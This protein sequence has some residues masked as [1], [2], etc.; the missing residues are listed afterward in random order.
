MSKKVIGIDLGTCFS[1]VSVIENGKPVIVSNSE[2]ARTTPSVV[3]LKDGDIKVGAAAN[4]QKVVNPKT[5]VSL[6]KRFMGVEY[7]K[8]QEAMKHI[9]Y[10]VVNVDGKP[11]VEIDG[12]KYSP[13][14][15]SSYI[16]N[17][18]KKTAEDYL[19]ETVT[20][21]VITCPA[22]FDSQ[23]REATKLAGE[24]CGLNVLRI[25]AEPTSSI[26]ASGIEVKGDTEKKVLVAD[27]GGGTT[28][29]SVCEIS[30]GMIEVRASSGS[31]YLGGSNIDDVVADYIITT[32]DKENGTDIRNSKD[33]AQSI[34][35]ILE[36][37]E[38]AKIELTTSPSTEISLPYITVK[39]NQ[40]LHLN[41]TLTKA[42]FAQLTQ[43][44]IDE[45]VSYG[46]DA[47]R[48]ANM[49]YKE[50]DC[51]LLVGG[52]SRST[53]FQE[54]LTRE[55]GVTLNKGVNPDEAVS[56]GAAIQAN[57]IVGGEGSSDL[58][59]L[60]INP[61]TLGIETMGGV[62][63]PLIEANT[64]IPCKKSQ[65]FTTA[66]DNQ[67]AVTIHVLQGERPLSKDN[68]S[69]G[70][71]TLDGIPPAS[72]HTPKVEVTFD[73]DANGI[74]TVTAVDEATKK[75]QHIT[76]ENKTSL[77]QEEID[78]I[79]AEAKEHEAEDNATKKKLELQNKCEALIYSTEQ[80]LD[81][82]K[83]KVTEDEKKYFEEKIEELNKMKE[84]EDYSNFDNLEK[85]IQEKWYGIS[86][87]AYGSNNSGNP[88]GDGMNFDNVN[89][90][91]MFN[92]AGTQSDVQSN[93]P[94]DEDEI[95]DAK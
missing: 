60:D 4:R 90:G 30:D 27:F 53:E 95:Q 89:F 92:K 73:I 9:Q 5:T 46:K 22:W 7:D 11:R 3:A 25:L 74:L 58:L 45:A 35:R 59:L 44:L 33:A 8:C 71:F 87:K 34:Q 66:V 83:E 47:M 80:T 13:E 79:K 31:V 10:N 50:L 26:L 14:E 49:D 88:F 86:A 6:I 63:T 62:M 2:G 82:L 17:K 21:A 85:E 55:F 81:N 84:S 32:F 37:A 16:I 42:K 29:F 76:I 52:Q 67:P 40:P 12:R 54:A 78:R 94:S 23:A 75:E 93:Q 1:A 18:M 64:T 19:G 36:A 72:A 28:D 51:I 43:H 61:I 39:D 57:I 41:I 70:M 24:M 69:L 48:K 38:K 65:I 68:K 15:I 91:D 20:D 77:T 56:L